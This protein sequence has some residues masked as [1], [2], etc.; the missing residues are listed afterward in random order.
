MDK[1]KT[2]KYSYENVEKIAQVNYK[3]AM[4]ATAC[5]IALHFGFFDDNLSDVSYILI[6]TLLSI[7]AWYSFR[8]YFVNVG[9]TVTSK[10][11]LVI[12]SVIAAFG[13]VNFLV[14]STTS[15]STGLP[16]NDFVFSIFKI[17]YYFIIISLIGFVVVCIRI[18]TISHKHSFPLRK[19]AIS[20]MIFIPLYMLVTCISNIRFIMET[21]AIVDYAM[22]NPVLSTE[23]PEFLSGIFSF[24]K[25]VWNLIILTPYYFLFFHFMKADR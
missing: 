2:K 10:S 1:M 15:L 8:A 19:I 5:F 17:L 4:I 24:V 6:S 11:L 3:Y 14:Y 16:T 23:P 13:G 25:F 12:I 9:D 22:A 7:Y 20:A 18:V 21:K